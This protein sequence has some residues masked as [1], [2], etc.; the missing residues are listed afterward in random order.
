MPA[1]LVNFKKPSQLP[2]QLP[3]QTFC[4]FTALKSGDRSIDGL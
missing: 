2:C 3:D 1:K 4:N